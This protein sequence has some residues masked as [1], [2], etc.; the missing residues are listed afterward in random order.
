MDNRLRKI[1]ITFPSGWVDISNENPEGPPTFINGN[2][3]E[4]GVLQ[5]STADYLSGEK[6]FAEFEGLISL[7]EN[8]GL[9]NEFGE[10]IIKESGDCKFGKYGF[11]QFSRPDFPFIT[12]WHLT[13][14]KDFIF[15]TFICS[16]LPEQKDVDEV[17][18]I[19][20]SIKRKGFFSKCSVHKRS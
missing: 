13:N 15:S 9:R 18:T 2:L 10:V 14:G 11:V 6:P 5:I 7:S 1:K 12:V 20:K 16:N 3:E 8:A 17:K 19:L 4:P